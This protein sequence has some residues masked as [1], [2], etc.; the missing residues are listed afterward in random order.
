MSQPK[1]LRPLLRVVAITTGLGCV[2]C[3]APFVFLWLSQPKFRS[4]NDAHLTD[5]A[6]LKGV[7]LVTPDGPVVAPV[8]GLSGDSIHADPAPDDD[9]RGY[10]PVFKSEFDLYPPELV[11]RVQLRHIVICTRLLLDAKPVAGVTDFRQG[12]LYLDLGSLT[13]NPV[14]SRQVI[15]H[16]FFHLLDYRNR[17]DI[18][19]DAEWATLNSPG[20]CYGLHKQ[21]ALSD[22]KAVERSDQVP[23]FLNQYSTTGVEEDKAELFAFLMVEPEYV[24]ARTTV[25]PVLR[26]KVAR[27]KVLLNTFCPEVDD[28][29]WDRVNQMRTRSQ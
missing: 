15:H 14:Y 9:L 23:G 4:L 8:G 12:N 24:G 2:V 3:L 19:R 20:F 13:V 5:S 22:P 18:Y 1:H 7:Y 10:L 21:S 6:T 28:A 25:D 17:G 29:F 16:E 11:R 27:I 26:A